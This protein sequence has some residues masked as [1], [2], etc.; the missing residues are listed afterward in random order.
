MSR[1]PGS[2]GFLGRF[3]GFSRVILG[4]W[5]VV[6]GSSIPGKSFV[7]ELIGDGRYV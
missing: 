1:S 4:F 7:F 2:T 5:W 3:G 6:L